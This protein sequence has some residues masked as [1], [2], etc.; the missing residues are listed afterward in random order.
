MNNTFTL[1]TGA[2]SGMGEATA[3]L[4]SK[5]RNVVLTARNEE[6]LSSVAKVCTENG[7]RV[8]Y[9]PFDLSKADEVATHLQQFIKDNEI[10]IDS[11]VHCAGMTE[12]LPISKTKYS[13]GLEVMNVNYFSAT[14]IISTLLKK[15]TNNRMLKNIVLITSIVAEYGI[16]Y[17]S[18]YSASKG[19]LTSLAMTLANELAPEVRVNVIAPGSFNTRITHTLFVDVESQN[20][21][22]NPPTLLKNGTVND[23]AKAIQFLLSD[24]SSY[25][26]GQ[27]LNVDGGEHIKV[28]I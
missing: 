5:T 10:V 2:S 21:E 4:L 19:A 8:L 9:F 11:F 23:V 1:I 12:L 22:W 16:K 25:I 27:V 14:E 24:D 17:Q 6:R 28:K 15:K 3:I 20:R 7:N 13:I 18:H 26:T